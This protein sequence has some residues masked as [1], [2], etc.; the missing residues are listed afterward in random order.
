MLTK[1][2][3]VGRGDPTSGPYSWLMGDP[4]EP[5]WLD[6]EEQEAWLGLVGVFVR[7][8]AALD[9]QLR[10]DSGISHFEY[11]VLAGLS[12]APERTLRMSVLAEW[13]EG[14]LSRLSQVV[15]RLERAEWVRRSPDP[16]DGRYTLATLLDDGLVALQA[17]APGHVEAVRR[18][19]FDALTEAQIRQLAS[20]TR[21]IAGAISAAE[22]TGPVD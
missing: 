22:A 2:L 1:T 16:T 13:T 4:E 9:R 12:T 10:R 3:P 17:A 5:R 18:F 19:V 20:I 15:A 6:A 11:Q 21:R 8:P 7:L 14:S